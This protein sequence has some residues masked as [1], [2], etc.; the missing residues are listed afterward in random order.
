MISTRKIKHKFVI[1]VALYISL[2]DHLNNS[3]NDFQGSSEKK[4][5][6]WK[7]KLSRYRHETKM[8]LNI[9]RSFLS[10]L[11]ERETEVG[12]EEKEI[13][14]RKNKFQRLVI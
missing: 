4:Y 3:I 14:E 9:L 11:G 12:R 10:L 7:V 1:S 8:K 2:L 13:E 5:T 6:N